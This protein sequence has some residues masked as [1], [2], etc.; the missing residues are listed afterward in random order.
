M[1]PKRRKPGVWCIEAFSD[2]SAAWVTHY[3]RDGTNVCYCDDG[4]VGRVERNLPGQDYDPRYDARIPYRVAR[5]L[6]RRWRKAKEQEEA[7]R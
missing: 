3:R 5:L 7:D 6:V 2:S 1:T 4:H